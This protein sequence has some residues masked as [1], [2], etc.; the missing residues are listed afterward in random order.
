MRNLE[1]LTEVYERLKI[2][3]M[4]GQADEDTVE[5]VELIEKERPDIQEDNDYYLKKFFR[6]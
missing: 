6:G 5:V 4:L 3:T 2:K 1:L